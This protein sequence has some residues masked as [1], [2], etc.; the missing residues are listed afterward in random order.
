ME[1]ALRMDPKDMRELFEEGWQSMRMNYYPP[2]PQ[3]DLVA[4]L[5]SHSDAVAL[6]ILLQIS[7]KQGLQIKK[8]GNWVPINPIPGA[9]IINI[10]DILEVYVFNQ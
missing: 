10:G 8:D 1:K 3:P 6:T 7:D 9:F 5:S 4:G 2:C